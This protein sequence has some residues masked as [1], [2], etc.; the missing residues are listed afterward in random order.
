MLTQIDTFGMQGAES[1]DEAQV[2]VACCLIYFANML[3]INCPLV[4]NSLETPACRCGRW[5]ASG[6]SVTTRCTTPVR[7][8]TGK[9]RQKRL[10]SW[11]NGEQTR[12]EVHEAVHTQP[13][14][15][16]R[17]PSAF[18]VACIA[19]L[20]VCFALCRSANDKRHMLHKLRACLGQCL[21]MSCRLQ[22]GGEASL[23]SAKLS[24]NFGY[25][26]SMRAHCQR[27][28]QTS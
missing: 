22:S 3:N 11:I 24:Q 20:D 10:R 15:E 28:H 6:S 7:M 26:D 9:R 8:L 25:A 23:C 17:A 27:I 19:Q 18:S 14:I 5:S 12:C 4:A 13:I 16:V 2:R 1:A 21:R